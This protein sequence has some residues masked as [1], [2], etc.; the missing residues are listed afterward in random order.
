MSADTYHLCLLIQISFV[1]SLGTTAN[2]TTFVQNPGSCQKIQFKTKKCIA[3]ISHSPPPT[4][5]ELFYKEETFIK[6]LIEYLSRQSFLVCSK[7]FY[8][9]DLDQ[10]SIRTGTFLWRKVR[11]R[12]SVPALTSFSSPPCHKTKINT[13]EIQGIQQK[14]KSVDKLI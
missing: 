7:S 8:E 10:I 3:L 9:T 6:I 11:W 5:V 1:M 13:E 4:T 2:H 14:Y 12:R